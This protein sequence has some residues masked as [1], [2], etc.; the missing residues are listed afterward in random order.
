MDKK[1]SI[2]KDNKSKQRGDIMDKTKH[3]EYII[4]KTHMTGKSMPD[5]LTQSTKFAAEPLPFNQAAVK[6]STA[7]ALQGPSCYTPTALS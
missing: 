4:N 7:H 3:S 2:P 5:L 6:Q 1:T